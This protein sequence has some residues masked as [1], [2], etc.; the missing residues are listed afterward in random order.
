MLTVS[1]GLSVGSSQRPNQP[2]EKSDTRPQYI[3]DS[4]RNHNISNPSGTAR[5]LSTRLGNRE[6]SGCYILAM[7][8]ELTHNINEYCRHLRTHSLSA[9]G[10][11]TLIFRLSRSSDHW[12][13]PVPHRVS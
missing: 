7:D 6:Y 11:I 8:I 2:V 9:L 4:H 13:V 5:I 12:E 1:L 10:L 3:Q